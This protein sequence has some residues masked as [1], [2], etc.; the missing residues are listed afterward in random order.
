MPEPDRSSL[1]TQPAETLTFQTPEYGPA[2][3]FY[4]RSGLDFTDISSELWR[5][6][7]YPDGQTVRVPYPAWL[8][9]NVN[10]HR[11]M[12]ANGQCH[13]VASGWRHLTWLPR[14]GAPH[15]VK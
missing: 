13:Y 2:T 8:H 15:F 1:S 10:G 7:N 11:I 12:Q 5:E 6:Y 4:N 3:P 14:D 9:A